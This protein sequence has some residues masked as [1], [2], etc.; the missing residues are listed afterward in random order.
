MEV[1]EG[2]PAEEE[3]AAVE[4]FRNRLRE[5]DYFAD[6][7]EITKLP[8]VRATDYARGFTIRINLEAPLK[9]M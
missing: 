4:L 5:S 6:E 3:A 8:P 9:V 2:P 7:T 1:Y